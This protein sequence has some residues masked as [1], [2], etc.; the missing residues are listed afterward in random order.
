M[1][2]SAYEGGRAGSSCGKLVEFFDAETGTEI[3]PVTVDEVSGAR[4]G[5]RRVRK[6]TPEGA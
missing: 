2:I 4:I 1:G 6:V 3:Q 5:P